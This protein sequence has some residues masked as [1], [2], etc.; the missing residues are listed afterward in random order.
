[1]CI[2]DLSGRTVVV[3]GANSGLG[4]EVT[5]GLAAKGAYVVMGCRNI[6][7]GKSAVEQIRKEVPDASLAVMQLDL[8]DL[9]TVRGFSSKY[10]KRASFT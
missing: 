10:K 9:S 4:Y 2:P 8:A 3:T 1:M 6:E 5:K 7:K